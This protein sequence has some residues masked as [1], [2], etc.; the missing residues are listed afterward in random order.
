MIPP[1]ARPQIPQLPQGHDQ[2]LH[3]VTEGLKAGTVPEIAIG[4]RC[5][6][7]SELLMERTVDGP[8]FT[9]LCT[10]HQW[11]SLPFYTLQG[12]PPV[13]PFCAV[14]IESGRGRARYAELQRQVGG[15]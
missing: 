1:S 11:A 14:E 10:R 5:F 6:L 12:L 4:D 15:F 9:R 7:G 2:F 3:G 8:D 13:C